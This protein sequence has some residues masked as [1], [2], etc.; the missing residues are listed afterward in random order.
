MLTGGGGLAHRLR[1][2]STPK[3]LEGVRGELTER[4]QSHHESLTVEARRTA[5]Q[6]ICRESAG[7]AHATECRQLVGS[8]W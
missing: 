4:R 1:S 8:R 2:L 5:V 6:H 3:H 7:W